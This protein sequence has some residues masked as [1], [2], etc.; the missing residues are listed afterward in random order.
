MECRCDKDNTDDAVAGEK[1]QSVNQIYQT[2]E[3]DVAF[4]SINFDSNTPQF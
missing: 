2:D 4:S 1:L 3:K